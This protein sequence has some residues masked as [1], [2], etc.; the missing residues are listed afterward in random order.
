MNLLS[1]SIEQ[2]RA[3]N[4][5]ASIQLVGALRGDSGP[6]CADPTNPDTDLR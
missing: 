4:I 3:K 2:S 5:L 6:E 1:L